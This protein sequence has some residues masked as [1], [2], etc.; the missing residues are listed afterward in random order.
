MD[1]VDRFINNRTSFTTFL[2]AAFTALVSGIVLWIISAKC[3]DRIVSEQIRALF[4]DMGALGSVSKSIPDELLGSSGE[5]L[6]K[7]GISP[8]MD[9]HLL[10]SWGNVRLLIFAVS[11]G[12]ALAVIAVFTFLTLKMFGKTYRELDK[13][14]LGCLRIADGS[15]TSMPLSGEDFSAICRVTEGIGLITERMRYMNSSVDAE[16]NFL[17]ELLT[18]L[19]HQLKTNLAV[20]RLN[21]DILSEIDSL[22]DEKREQLCGEISD[23]LDSMESL[24][25]ASLKLA[26]LNADSVDYD[27]S[28]RDLTMTCSQ[29][30]ANIAPLMRSA[31]VELSFTADEQIVMPHDAIW[32]CEAVENVIKNALD[33]AECTEIN[34]SLRQDPSVTVVTVSDNGVGIPQSDIPNL[35]KRFGRKSG[36]NTMRSVGVGLSIARRIVQAHSGDIFVYSETDKGTVFELSFVSN[37]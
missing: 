9:P 18:D 19:S 12:A 2:A 20:V 17:K 8:D 24:V 34:V 10:G 31:G 22:S 28:S 25:I 27:M 6:R 14:Y 32:L 23:N 29:A 33:H 7:Y 11:F 30:V 16:K 35:W 36:D 15:S 5:S 1:R 4:G 3:A 21:S 37:W 26:K 13:I